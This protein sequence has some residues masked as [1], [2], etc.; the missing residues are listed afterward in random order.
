MRP[1]VRSFG[2]IPIPRRPGTVSASTWPAR[3]RLG[4]ANG[5]RPGCSSGKPPRGRSSPPRL[6][7]PASR[8]DG[9]RGHPLHSSAPRSLL[10]FRAV[11]AARFLRARFVRSLPLVPVVFL[12]M[13]GMAHAAEVVI[14]P[15]VSASP[16]EDFGGWTFKMAIASIS[17]IV[18]VALLLISAYLRFAPRFYL[19]EGSGNAPPVRP[20]ARAG[21]PVAAVALDAPPLPAPAPA[22]PQPEAAARGRADRRLPAPAAPPR[23]PPPRPLPAAAPLLPRLPPP[24][25]PGR[26]PPRSRKGPSSSTRRRSTASWPRSSPRAP[27]GASRRVAPVARRPAPPAARPRAD[28]PVSRSG[29]RRVRMNPCNSP[30]TRWPTG[31][32]PNRWP[33]GSPGRDRWSAP[34]SEPACGR[35][36]ASWCPRPSAWSRKSRASSRAGIPRAPG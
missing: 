11:P 8:R 33:T 24:L 28:G 35:T 29:R 23:R 6:H 16:A 32:W 36:S 10:E 13:Q 2:G 5:Q 20:Q 19:G 21:A 1:L 9:R 12:A 18:V 31:R 30:S 34:S 3:C 15:N 22:A 17:L 14:T 25:R 7:F 4:G 27:T 26:R